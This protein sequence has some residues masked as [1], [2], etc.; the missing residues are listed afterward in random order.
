MKKSF[1]LVF[2]LCINLIVFAQTK[3]IIEIN[4]YVG[5]SSPQSDFKNLS[6]TGYSLGLSIDR[7]LSSKF[8]LGLDL[9]Y[10]ST[11]FKNGLDYSIIPNPYGVLSNVQGEWSSTN[12]TFGPTYKLGNSKIET[13]IYAKAGVS[14]VKSPNERLIFTGASFPDFEIFDLREQNVTSFALTSGIRFSYPLNNKVSFFVNPQ[15]IISGAEI[16]YYYKDPSIAYFPGPEGADNFFEPG[17]LAQDPGKE[18]VVKPSYLNLNAGI[19]FS[20]GGDSK[21]PITQNSIN[22]SRINKKCSAAELKLPLN[23]KKYFMHKKERP[24]Y[25]WENSEFNKPSSYVVRFYDSNKNEVYSKNTETNL[26]KHNREIESI[27]KKYASIEGSRI[28]WDVETV[29]E[30]DCENEI[31]EQNVLLIALTVPGIFHNIYDL[32]CDEPSYTNNGK[33][34]LTGKIE[35]HNDDQ[36]SPLTITTLNITAGGSTIT[37]PITDLYNCTSGTT[38]TSIVIQPN[39]DNEYCFNIEIPISSTEITSNVS[40]EIMAGTTVLSQN[41]QSYTDEIP[42]CACNTCDRW[43]YNDTEHALKKFNYNDHPFNFQIVQELQILG[44]DPIMEVKAEII[45]VQHIAND[46]Q[47]YACTKHENKMGLFSFHTMQPREIYNKP[48]WAFNGNG[49]IGW[50]NAGGSIDENNDRYTNQVIWRAKV[51]VI[52]VDFS[53]KQRFVMPISLPDPSSLDCC[54]HNYKVC[55]RYTFTDVNCITCSYEQCYTSDGKSTPIV[56]GNP[57]GGVSN[58][59]PNVKLNKI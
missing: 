11:G 27:Y 35:F 15:Y 55:V 36:S 32:N 21:R 20:L 26:L 25:K 18:A 34:R 17:I 42:D 19:K 45:S 10:Q 38:V 51:P 43:E 54:E 5:L 53:K 47:C 14:M 12:I 7:Y 1:L 33:L 16:N 58:K 8:A 52:G 30:N 24:S 6:D 2:V 3:K 59:V 29:F 31:S 39:D 50:N 44:I 4:P 9:N 13:E 56:I 41:S 28:Y 40:G 48:F 57:T 22:E 23:G 49:V 37:I 46:P